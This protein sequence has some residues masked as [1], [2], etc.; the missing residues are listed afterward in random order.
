V[1]VH[2]NPRIL[3]IDE[4][5]AVGDEEF[6]RRCFEHLYKLRNDGVTIVMVTHSLDLV[7]SMC[8]RAAWL[9]HGKM[10]AEGPA[11]DVV[12][13]YLDKVNHAEAE[14]LEAEDRARAEFEAAQEAVARPVGAPAERPIV[15]GEIEVLDE[16]LRPSRLFNTRK[17]LTLRIHYHCRVPVESPLFSF[18]L[19]TQSGVLVA[20]PGMKRTQTSGTLYEGWGHIDYTVPDLAVATGEYSITVAVHDTKATM[21]I[22]KKE[23]VVTLRV[24]STPPVYGLVDLMGTW[25][26]MQPREAEHGS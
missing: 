17:P 23:R 3:I 24:D 16:D 25:G 4:V 9:D 13:E 18:T 26:P 14:R 21:V 11:V 5:I 2:V 8:D 10:L 6:Q 20:H 12:H 1:A 19:E 7:R 22:D 15:L